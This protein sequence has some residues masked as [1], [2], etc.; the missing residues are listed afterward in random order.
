MTA[1]N[2]DL[3]VI[4][5]TLLAARE[6]V[7]ILSHPF[8]D[9]DSIGSTFGIGGILAAAGVQV[10]PVL[11]DL[12][13]VYE[14][15]AAGFKV[16]RPPV[17]LDG[18]T[19]LVLDCGTVS[20]L[21]ETGQSLENA[22]RVINIDHHLHNEYFG[23]LNYVDSSAAAVGEIIHRLFQDYPQYYNRQIAQA[24]FTALVTDTGRFSYSNTTA[25]VFQTAAVLV[26]RGAC[27]DITYEHLYLNRTLTYYE[28][29]V[30][31]LSL[32]ELHFS[33]QVA[34]LPLNYG[35]LN[36]HDLQDWELEEINDYPRSLAGIKV[37]IVLREVELG[38][39][40]ASLRSRELDVAKIARS[41][42]GG[43]H[44]NA[45]GITLLMP[46][47]QA[48]NQLLNILEREGGL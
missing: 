12:P 29:L 5:D 20:R 22:L 19:A 15:L 11:P 35:L 37:S 18:K 14:F 26:E 31:A 23:D 17:N 41:L 48:R 40:K 24:L 25:Q 9:G 47:Q 38:I 6:P 39:V 13:A 28:F 43:G 8:P 42:G 45:A 10:E 44:R 16:H 33:R 7:V 36:R 21:K 34:L 32:I 27:P 2:C 46:L 1:R 4:R 3:S 30:Q